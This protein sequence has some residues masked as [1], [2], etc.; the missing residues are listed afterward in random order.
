MSIYFLLAAY[1]IG[2]VH[3]KSKLVR[4]FSPD[5]LGVIMFVFIAAIFVECL[6]ISKLIGK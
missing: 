4:H 6:F 3:V 1:G 2:I 5:K